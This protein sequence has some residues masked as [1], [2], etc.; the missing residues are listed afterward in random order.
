[1]PLNTTL[2]AAAGEHHV[3]YKLSCFGYLAALVRQGSP[4][5]DLLASNQDGGRTVGI[6][7]KTTSD[8]R[9]WSGPKNKKVLSELQ[10]PLATA[11]F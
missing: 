6:Q 1:M 9:R 7:V 11:T 10:F 8:A 4:A 2:V 3:A 5:I